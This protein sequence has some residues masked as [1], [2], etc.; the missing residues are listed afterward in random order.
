MQWTTLRG[1]KIVDAGDAYFFRWITLK[2][3]ANW[4]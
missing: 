4:T 2:K 3:M 1:L